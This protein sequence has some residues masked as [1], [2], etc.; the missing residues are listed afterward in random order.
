MILRRYFQQCH[1]PS[2]RRK[3]EN[4]LGHPPDL[5]GLEL[6]VVAANGLVCSAITKC[7][8]EEGLYVPAAQHSTALRASVDASRG[9]AA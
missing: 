3:D 5:G 8:K 9:S 7:V 4:N 6:A 1:A 2:V